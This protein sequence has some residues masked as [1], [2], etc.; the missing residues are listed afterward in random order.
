LCFCNCHC[1]S[2]PPFTQLRKAEEEAQ[3]KRDAQL[4]ASGAA[5]DAHRALLLR[6]LEEE[7]NYIEVVSGFCFFTGFVLCNVCIVLLC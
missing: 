5:R 6:Y 3:A 4:A 1:C 2:K 7:S